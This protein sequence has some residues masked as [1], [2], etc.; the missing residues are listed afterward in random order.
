AGLGR[1]QE[2]P[3]AIGPGSAAPALSVKTWLK[4]TPVAGFEPGKTY[5]VE[6]WATWCGPCIQTIPHVTK[7]AQENPDITFMGIGI[8]EEEGPQ[9]K[10][11]V[12]KMGD[13]MGYNVGYSGNQD[14]MAVSW[15]KAAGQNG[16]PTAFIIKDAQVAWVGHP[17][18]MDGPL[19]E[20]KAGTFDTA[21]FKAKFDAAAAKT[22]EQMAANE[23]LGAVAKLYKD[24]KK[25]EAKA[26]LAKF[27]AAHPAL[28]SSTDAMAFDWLATEDPKAWDTRAKALAASEKQ[29]DLQMLM[30][31]AVRRSGTPTGAPMARRAVELGL[32]AKPE[33]MTVLMYARYVYKKTGDT[34]LALA[35]VNKMLAILPTSEY[36]DEAE[37]KANLIADKTD[38]EAKA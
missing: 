22:R 25:T 14:A 38:L 30:S 10:A 20:I 5:V 32:K 23:E 11:F 35:V 19:A 37:L 18:S 28:K 15:M 16:I 4:G 17:M 31:F 12:D 26:A 34:K 36:K 24:G 8:W 29:D 13:K 2:A 21:V 3:T 33:D 1:A 27:S 9:L 6:F 7:L